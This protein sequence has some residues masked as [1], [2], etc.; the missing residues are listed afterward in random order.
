MYVH[1]WASFE[2][3]AIVCYVQLVCW[4]NKTYHMGLKIQYQN[5]CKLINQQISI[6]EF[7]GCCSYN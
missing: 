3:I 1:L 7:Q 4:L 5:F 6:F 2:S